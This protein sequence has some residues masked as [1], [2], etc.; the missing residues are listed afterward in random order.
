MHVFYPIRYPIHQLPNFSSVEALFFSIYYY[1]FVFFLWPSIYWGRPMEGGNSVCSK[2]FAFGWL[3]SSPVYLF[4][5]FLL[6]FEIVCVLVA[7]PILSPNVSSTGG[8][9]SPFFPL[10]LLMIY[11]EIV[12]RRQS[13]WIFHPKKKQK[14]KKC[15]TA[16]TGS[17]KRGA[18]TIRKKKLSRWPP[19]LC[20]RGTEFVF[21]KRSA[22]EILPSSFL[23][24]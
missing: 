22:K 17:F 18:F 6:S 8:L 20:G 9:I 4:L 12:L 7:A 24:P 21:R 23:S 5:F 15:R 19:S 1:Y 14:T 2:P 16:T 11:N 13:R 10:C 3:G